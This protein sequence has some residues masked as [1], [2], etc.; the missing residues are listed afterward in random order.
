MLEISSFSLSYV[1]DTPE[2]VAIKLPVAGLWS[3]SAAWMIDL[4]IRGGVYIFLAIVLS[5]TGLFGQG[6][7][8]ISVFVLEWFYPVFYE[9]FNNGKTPGKKIIG[10]KVVNTNGSQLDWV[11]SMTRNIIRFIDM[12]PLVYGIGFISVL[13]S[14]HSQRIGDI[15]AGTIVIYDNQHNTDAFDDQLFSASNKSSIHKSFITSLTL[16]ERRAFIAFAERFDSLSVPR[17]EELIS[18]ISPVLKKY[19]INGNI[20][21]IKEISEAII[22]TK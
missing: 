12:L 18:I 3:R 20:N 15:V 5:I 11:A 7:L 4:L 10:I 13:L 2:G 14:T 16:D 8:L 22:N 19:N 21:S 6:V 1:V 9:V 17:K